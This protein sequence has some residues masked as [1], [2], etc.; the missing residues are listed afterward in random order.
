MTNRDLDD[1]LD[2]RLG[3]AQQ[4][5]QQSA[6]QDDVSYTRMTVRV[7]VETLRTLSAVA[8][9][10]GRNLSDICADI[11]EPEAE[12]LGEEF[13]INMRRIASRQRRARTPKSQ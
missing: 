9:L 5:P 12:R 6:Q 11:L 7:P 10:Q 4:S 8:A 1:G 13:G 3:Q 2:I